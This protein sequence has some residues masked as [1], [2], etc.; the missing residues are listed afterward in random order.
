MAEIRVTKIYNPEEKQAEEKKLLRVAAYCRVSTKSD[1]QHLSYDTQVAVYSEKIRAEPGWTMAGIYADHGISGTQAERRPQF[2]QMVQDC[3]DGKIDAIICKS[4]SRFSR[5]TL[6]AVNY[7]RKLRSLGIRL[8]FEKEGIDTDSE[9]SEMLLTVLA[10]FAQEESHSHSENV[11]WGKRKRLQKGHALLIPVYGY[12]KNEE[13][14][15]YEI[16]PEEAEAVRLIFDLYEHGTSVPEITRTLKD[17]GYP[18]PNGET[19]VWDESRIHYM[20]MNEKYA[21]DL[22]TQKFYKKSYMDYRCY[23]NDGLL[24]GKMLKDHHEPIVPRKQFDRCNVILELKKKST[25]SQYP[26]GDYLRCPYCGHVLRHRRLEIQNIDSHFC[27]EGEGACRKFAIMAIPVKKAI[28]DAWNSL[29][30]AEVERISTMKLRR[31]AEEAGKLLEGKA[32]HPAFDAVD[33]WWLDE[34]V[35]KIEF[36]QHSYTASDLKL[37]EPEQAKVLDDRTITITWRCGLMTAIPSGV[38]RDSHDP[39]HKAKL[40]DGYLLRYQDRYPKLAEEVRKKQ[41]E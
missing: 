9:Y 33:Y 12:R 34:Y 29:D 14:D 24:P 20:I 16:V 13:D 36:G 1:E 5:N 22:Q 25:P 17:R 27:C 26:F 6:D 40:W 32:A 15:T 19:K 28:L 30:L 35:A 31:K 11:K 10:A 39:R 37:M 4:V 3:E 18:M 21:G 2:L 41:A 23:R 8:I 7:M 38:V